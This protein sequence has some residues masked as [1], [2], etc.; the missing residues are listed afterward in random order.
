MESPQPT[1]AEVRAFNDAHDANPDAVTTPRV[2]REF[3]LAGDA[4]F[5][6]ETPDGKH[7]TYRIEKIEATDRWPTVWFAKM[8][9][10]PD[11]DGDYSYVGKLCDFTGQ[12]RVTAK[13]V[14]PADAYPIRLLNRVLC[15]VWGDDHAAIERAGFK[16][17]HE[18]RCGRCARRL[19][20]PESVTRGIGPE[21]AKLLGY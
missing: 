13:S 11:N 17:F 2:T 12:V 10:G 5:T 15:R 4:I 8:L 7:Y 6:V 20:T 9:T 19:T 18:G 21:C 3:I 1:V 14:L 16:V